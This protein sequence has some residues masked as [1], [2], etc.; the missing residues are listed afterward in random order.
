MNTLYYAIE[1]LLGP[2]LIGISLLALYDY[3]QS[4]GRRRRFEEKQEREKLEKELQRL[5]DL[6]DKHY[7]HYAKVVS[8]ARSD[9]IGKV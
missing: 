5:R 6:I 2:F 7:N 9:V 1:I 3:I 8:F 4:S